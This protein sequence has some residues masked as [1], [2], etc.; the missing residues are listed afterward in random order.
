MGNGCYIF[1]VVSDQIC[2]LLHITL[3]H[4]P[5]N[6]SIDGGDFRYKGK[7]IDDASPAFNVDESS[8]D[9]SKLMLLVNDDNITPN[10][11]PTKQFKSF[12]KFVGD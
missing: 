2:N 12:T 10:G 5:Y 11:D 7:A 4:G 8:N 9:Q 3:N 6:E 1:G